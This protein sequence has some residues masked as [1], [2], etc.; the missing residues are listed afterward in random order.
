MIFD[1]VR[2]PRTHILKRYLNVSPEGKVKRIGNPL[3]MYSIMM[4]TRIQVM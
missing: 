4:Y 3:V 2:I 1:Q